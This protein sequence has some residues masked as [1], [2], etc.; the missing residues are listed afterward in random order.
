MSQITLNLNN[1]AANTGITFDIDLPQISMENGPF[2]LVCAF[3]PL[4][5]FNYML[6][7]QSFIHYC[8]NQQQCN[9]C[10]GSINLGAS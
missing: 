10:N 8:G 7:L 5:K 4:N 9:Q 6:C 1:S 2:R 3:H